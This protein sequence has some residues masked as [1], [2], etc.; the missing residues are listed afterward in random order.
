M[1]PVVQLGNSYAPCHTIPHT[2]LI[3]SGVTT[4]HVPD[5]R[6]VTVVL[7]QR[8]TQHTNTSWKGKQQPLTSVQQVQLYAI[9]DH[10]CGFCHR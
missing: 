10:L 4:N 9:P 5:T 3:N 6:A 8:N 2:C 7:A 1:S